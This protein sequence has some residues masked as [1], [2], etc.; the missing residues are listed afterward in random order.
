MDYQFLSQKKI[1][2]QQLEDYE[3]EKYKEDLTKN[4]ETTFG[5]IPVGGRR[6]NKRKTRRK[7]NKLTKRKS[8]KRK[9]RKY[10]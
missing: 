2:D 3:D 6:K 1:G 4:M 7:V 8:R 5:Q 10:F 9:T